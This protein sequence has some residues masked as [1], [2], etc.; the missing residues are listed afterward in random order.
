MNKKKFK[1]VECPYCGESNQG[2]ELQYIL[3]HMKDLYPSFHMEV[4]SSYKC[5]ECELIFTIY[6]CVNVDF[7]TR[8]K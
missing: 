1:K 4:N 3:D 5:K 2:E 8:K 7:E 6:T